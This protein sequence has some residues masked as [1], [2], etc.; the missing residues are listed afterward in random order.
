M[1]LSGRLVTYLRIESTVNPALLPTNIYS[2]LKAEL[3]KIV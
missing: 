3:Q 1:S 2:V